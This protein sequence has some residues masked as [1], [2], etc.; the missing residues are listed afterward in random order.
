MSMKETINRLRQDYFELKAAMCREQRQLASDARCF[1]KELEY[2]LN[3]H[4]RIEIES[5]IKDCDSAIDSLK[6]KEAC[7][8]DFVDGVSYSFRQL[9]DMVGLRI[10]AFPTSVMV[11]ANEIVMKRF[12]DWQPDHKKHGAMQV[13][14]YYGVLGV[15][16]IPCEIQVVSMLTGKFWDVEHSALYK[17]APGFKGAINANFEIRDLYKE[18]MNK[19]AEFETA[20]EIAIQKG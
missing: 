11:A 14:K 4:E 19:L 15:E 5:R 7:G 17:P 10:L 6:R 2:S 18:V 13:Y 3:E 20:F 9:K 8:R 1:L 16:K 12:G